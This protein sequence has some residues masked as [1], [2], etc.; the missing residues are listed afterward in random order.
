MLSLAYRRTRTGLGQFG[1]ICRVAA[2]LGG[3]RGPVVAP[4][5]IVLALLL[6]L[7]GSAQARDRLAANVAQH[8]AS[9]VVVEL[10]TSQGCSRCPPADRILGQLAE[11]EDTIAI[12]LH[13][14]YWDYLG[15]KDELARPAFSDRQRYYQKTLR[16]STMYTPQMV[17][18][19][20]IDV[21]GSDAN[22]I[23]QAISEMRSRLEGSYVPVS[24]D[25][26][27][28]ML[29][30]SI[31]AA[32][33]N[34]AYRSAKVILIAMRR[35]HTVSIMRGENRGRRLTYHNVTRELM[36]AGRWDGNATTF[37]VPH[38]RIMSDNADMC[39]VILQD[40]A[41]GVIFAGAKWMDLPAGG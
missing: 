19:G 33:E 37:I 25:M 8:A 38:D 7:G 5:L 40:E 20:S 4:A 2:C 26:S 14:D 15:W 27:D 31:G 17:V 22:A 13:V 3:M 30:V 6:A 32:P 18:A 35:S 21:V 12:A 41:T 24:L 28:G 9:P 34:A 1:P 36:T 11:R 16:E 23:E 29:Q 10:F 39:A